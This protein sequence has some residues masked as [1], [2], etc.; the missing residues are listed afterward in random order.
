MAELKI[1]PAVP[2]KIV[3][4]GPAK[5]VTGTLGTKEVSPIS[6]KTVGVGQKVQNALSSAAGYVAAHPYKTILGVAALAGATYGAHAAYKAYTTVAQPMC[7]RVRNL[8]FHATC[9]DTL[10]A[11]LSEELR[12][13]SVLHAAGTVVEMA[14]TNPTVISIGN[15][16]KA[17]GETVKADASAVGQGIAKTRLA[18]TAVSGYVAANEAIKSAASSVA[19][20]ATTAKQSITDFVAEDAGHVTTGI[21][22]TTAYKKVSGAVEIATAATKNVAESFTTSPYTRTSVSAM[23]YAVD[24]AQGAIS[25]VVTFLKDQP[26]SVAL[27][28]LAFAIK[29]LASSVFARSRAFMSARSPANI[30]TGIAQFRQVAQQRLLFAQG[31]R[32]AAHRAAFAAL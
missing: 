14:A 10:G 12:S 21:T 11:K 7:A 29:K 16:F 26:A 6:T 32:A 19:A 1:R 28:S 17:A 30:Q 3:S 5:P 4:T 27:L 8:N 20:T 9:P 2:Q 25:S 31:Q 24:K 15:A 22:S 18:Q 23:G 13:G